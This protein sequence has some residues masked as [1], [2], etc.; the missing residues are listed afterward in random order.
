M[1]SPRKVMQPEVHFVYRNA[2]E[3]N[4]LIEILNILLSELFPLGKMCG[5]QKN[6]D[7]LVLVKVWLPF[8][9]LNYLI[10]SN[11]TCCIKTSYVLE[12]CFKDMGLEA[13][14][15]GLVINSYVRINGHSL[16]E[17]WN[18]HE[19]PNKSQITQSILQNGWLCLFWLKSLPL[20]CTS[21]K[22]SLVS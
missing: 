10:C 20:H 6:V 16:K 4:L 21:L 2:F 3:R 11:L 22:V 5:L 7:L 9:K 12:I 19:L 8:F 13:R 1:T 17:H 14:R 15:Q 18:L